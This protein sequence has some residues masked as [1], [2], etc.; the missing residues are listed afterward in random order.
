MHG[1]ARREKK[2]GNWKNEKGHNTVL[3]NGSRDKHMVSSVKHIFVYAIIIYTNGN[4]LQ[5]VYTRPNK[6]SEKKRMRQPKMQPT[7]QPINK[8]TNKTDL[9]TMS[10]NL[11]TE[12]N[13][14]RFWPLHKLKCTWLQTIECTANWIKRSQDS[15]FIISMVYL[16]LL[17]LPLFRFVNLFCAIIV[18]GSN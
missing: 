13:G 18:N 14:K 6:E 8:Q 1:T 17:R 9:H 11:N 10:K 12:F 3:M 15:L 7:N 5:S 4:G 2:N 16:A